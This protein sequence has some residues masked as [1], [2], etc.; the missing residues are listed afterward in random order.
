ME[1]GSAKRQDKGSIALRVLDV[2]SRKPEGI[3]ASS[4]TF[5][6]LIPRICSAYDTGITRTNLVGVFED[7]Q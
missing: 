3:R 4:R 6:F 2:V 1:T 5:R 7:V